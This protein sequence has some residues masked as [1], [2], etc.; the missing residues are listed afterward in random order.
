MLQLTDVFYVLLKP[1]M[2]TISFIFYTLNDIIYIRN[3]ALEHCSALD[4]SDDCTTE[5]M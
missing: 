1:Y 5:I 3:F 4:E 2:I